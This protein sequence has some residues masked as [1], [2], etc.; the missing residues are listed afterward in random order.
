MGVVGKVVDLVW[1]ILW[2]I[3]ALVSALQIEIGRKFSRSVACGFAQC[4]DE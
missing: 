1:T 4:I 3:P 2:T